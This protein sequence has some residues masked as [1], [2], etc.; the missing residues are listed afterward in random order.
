M[1]SY[2]NLL[3]KGLKDQY[4]GMNIKQKKGIKIQQMS[5]DIFLIHTF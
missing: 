4:L 3:A 2:Q 5:I 1:K